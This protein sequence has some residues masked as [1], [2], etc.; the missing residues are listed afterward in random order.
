M[1]N[2]FVYES[3]M[4]KARE[5]F[6]AA[7]EYSF[8]LPAGEHLLMCHGAAGGS[9]YNNYHNLGGVSYGII[10]LNQ[11]TPM[12][13]YVGGNGG[14]PGVNGY[15]I[16]DGGYNG[17]GSGGRAY[18]N[19]A[20]YKAGA[21]G[22]GA[23]DIR[24][25]TPGEMSPDEPY[26]PTIPSGYKRV[27]YLN[28]NSAYFN[29]G[30]IATENT[31]F[32]FSVEYETKSSSNTEYAILGT[33]SGQN[34]N[35]GWA[36]W[37]NSY[38]DN[39]PKMASIYGTMEWGSGASAGV[40][41]IPTRIPSNTRAVYQVDKWGTFVNGH[42]LCYNS[43]I[44]GSPQSDQTI[45]FCCVRRANS[46]MSARIFNGKAY[47]LR[48]FEYENGEHV[49]KMELIP[50]IRLSDNVCGFYDTQNDTFI[51]RIQYQGDASPG[52]ATT[53]T[54]DRPVVT[55]RYKPTIPD[56]YTQLEY[57]Q[58]PG[59]I[60]FD[61]GYNANVNTAIT[62]RD[63]ITSGTS[64]ECI[65]GTQSGTNVN[66]GWACWQ[67]MNGSYLGLASIYGTMS[68]SESYLY[69]TGI[70][71]GYSAFYRVEKDRTFVNLKQL[72]SYEPSG[73]PE[74]NRSLFIMAC[75]RENGFA[76]NAITG[77]LYHFRIY[78]KQADDTYELVHEFVPCKRVSDDVIG[79]YDTVADPVSGD[80]QFLE[81]IS[82]GNVLTAGPTGNFP[83][84][85]YD[86]TDVSGASGT[87]PAVY[88]SLNTRIMVAG[89]GGGGL[90]W[91]NNS[92]ENY[93]DN[94]LYL[95]YLGYAGLGGGINGGFREIR[96]NAT[97]DRIYAT[98][99]S[100]A[101][102]GFGQSGR[103]SA[104]NNYYGYSG[105]SGGGGGW[106]GGYASTSTATYTDAS[107]GGGSGYV[108][109]S[110]S[111]IPQ[112]YMENYQPYQMTKTFMGG[113][114]A[115]SA[116]VRVCEP[117]ETPHAGDVITIYGFGKKQRIDLPPGQYRLKCWGA[118]G[119]GYYNATYIARG[120]YAEGVLTLTTPATLYA[121]VGGSGMYH[122][123]ISYD[124][125][126]QM[127]PD[128]S[129]NGGGAATLYGQQTAC[130]YTGFPGGG[131]SDIRINTDSLN[132][133]VIVAGGAAGTAC[134][135]GS[136][137][138]KGGVGGGTT[139]GEG[140]YPNQQSRNCY[141]SGPGTQTG[142]VPAELDAIMGG[143]GYGGNSSGGGTPYVS[144]G[145]GGGWYGGGSSARIYGN[146]QSY[147]TGPA[148]GGSGYTFTEGSYKPDGYLLSDDYKLTEPLLVAGGNDLPLGVSKIVIEVIDTKIVRVLCRDQY[149]IKYYDEDLGRW[150]V[151]L[152]AE[153]SPELFMEYG[154]LN[155]NSDEGLDDNYELLIYDPED[156]TSKLEMNVVPNEQTITNETMTDITIR[157]MSQ[158]LDF[159]PSVY[160]INITARRQTL[161]VGT[162]ITTTFKVKKKTQTDDTAKVFYVTYSDGN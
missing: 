85:D 57:L 76:G 100:G 157:D 130:Y 73:T 79:L 89:G 137:L 151:I 120:G 20:S 55:E 63:T 132:A 105:A 116:C 84:V 28:V 129:F 62:F 82:S 38:Y 94:R 39:T 122:N 95:N 133:R 160:D 60:Y 47:Y 145:G 131:A 124:Y 80:H 114:Y 77:K 34:T 21:G 9:T 64:N 8:T 40:Y 14:D 2:I 81:P 66:P 149:G 75:R 49:L 50:C 152:D 104:Q 69:S 5:E 1:A 142:A 36:V 65:F 35:P 86:G 24:I 27:E 4:W 162:K 90:P 74:P 125:T 70:P 46:I 112:D 148:H 22:G 25:H 102:F 143:F 54:M 115:E 126:Y 13:A 155:M 52:P 110:S 51:P 140:I 99:D 43:D 83:I 10:N 141:L 32:V 91:T 16:G 135:S 19:N 108:L 45:I 12:H 72:S 139:G 87:D 11:A 56:E 53:G 96:T 154:S 33:Q 161:S 111:Y 106:F 107:G 67:Y 92:V 31:T 156:T 147:Y 136:I 37:L 18:Y 88:A 138:S 159:D 93:Q 103:N 117:C 123:M 109:T 6:T 7:G 113:G 26:T 158:K 128:L 48:A 44:T 59:G 23:S 17:G 30:Y 127:R 98:Q 61:S 121:Y 78:E 153:L 41:M 29:T 58:T 71:Y 150:K 118:C 68:W 119:G 42:P 3:R 101:S 97:V 134:C 146:N 15:D 144:A